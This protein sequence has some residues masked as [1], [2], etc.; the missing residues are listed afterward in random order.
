MIT[1]LNRPPR[2]VLSENPAI[3]R[4][5]SSLTGVENLHLK[6]SVIMSSTIGTDVL[7]PPEGGSAETDI[8][9][10][11]QA[12]F[13]RQSPYSHF[14]LPDNPAA[15]A[16]VDNLIRNYTVEVGEGQGDPPSYVYSL[17]QNRYVLPGRMPLWKHNSFYAQY[18][19]VWQ[20]IITVK[21]FL[22]L[23]PK[24][25][26]TKPAQTQKLYWLC[27]YAPAEGHTISLKINLRFN[28]GTSADWVKTNFSGTLTQYAI[29]Q[30]HT[31]YN[32]LGIP[33]KIAAD[34]PGL[35]VISYSVTAIDGETAVSET[36]EYIVNSKLTP[37]S[38][39]LAFRNSLGTFDTV[40]LN[41]IGELNM[42]FDPEN[43]NIHGTSAGYPLS[44]TLRT[45]ANAK[46]KASTGW[47]TA[48]ERL[49]MSELLT[50]REV[51]QIA[52]S[53]LYPVVITAQGVTLS[54]DRDYLSAVNIEFKPV[55]TYIE[56]HGA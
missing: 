11:L 27:D 33:A 20:W 2:V 8:S 39:E 42:D 24:V 40:M 23:A 10:Y 29:Y 9:D 3:V 41:G 18:A 15:W 53:K 35:E 22:T 54:R 25:R 12:L 38:I 45:E 13:S 5:S 43:V 28:D 44:R 6:V 37:G 34:Y 1:Y 55:S 48:D 30:F 50:S 26:F 51:Y 52:G 4:L 19:S 36:R 31:G 46:V 16:A 7:Y 14:T 17:L 32:S 21:P 47:I 56:E 49:Y